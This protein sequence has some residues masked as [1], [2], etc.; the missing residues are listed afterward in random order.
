MPF[1][2]EYRNRYFA[3]SGKAINL[4]RLEFLGN[5]TPKFR[6]GLGAAARSLPQYLIGGRRSVT[7]SVEPDR[8]A[9]APPPARLSEKDRL[10]P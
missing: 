7:R 3:E 8:T 6:L 2:R 5:L 10:L 9:P 1:F 4:G